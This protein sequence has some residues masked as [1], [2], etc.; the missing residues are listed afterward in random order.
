MLH[1]RGVACSRTSAYNAPGNGQC[2][3][4][5]GI[6][7]SAIK[8]GLTSPNLDIARWQTALA[9]ALH[10]VRSLLCRATNGTPHERFF[11]FRR[12]STFGISVPTWRSTPGPV[13]LRR[14]GRPS[15]YDL[16]VE[17][18]E[19]VHATP[20]YAHVRFP[21]GRETTVP[22]RDVAPVRGVLSGS[23][24]DAEPGPALDA[25][26]APS[27][28]PF[29]RPPF[30]PSVPPREQTEASSE[31][32]SHRTYDDQNVC[33]VRA[34]DVRESEAG[35]APSVPE[36]SPAAQP[37]RSSRQRKPVERYGAVPYW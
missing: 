23:S 5:N 28:D 12:R 14:H 10:F 19:L 17:E 21:S 32:P 26:F 11:Y 13:Y 4:Y 2:E 35:P 34:N 15:K 31:T 3:R 37:R 29:D 25:Q 33:N 1:E 6:I 24:P 22:L 18:V 7:W 16:V 8:L 20:Q 9:D 27:R 30:D 36:T